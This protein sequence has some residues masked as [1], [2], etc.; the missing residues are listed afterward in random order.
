MYAVIFRAEPDLLDDDYYDT[1]KLLRDLAFNEYRCRE[2]VAVTE[3]GTEIAV[4][5]WD[6]EEDIRAWR[7]ASEHRVAQRQGLMKWYKSFRVDVVEVK[8]S[9][10]RERRA[11]EARET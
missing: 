9:Y 8:R 10:T 5:Y 11:L 1:V 2:F 4:S 7:E 6:S 3:G